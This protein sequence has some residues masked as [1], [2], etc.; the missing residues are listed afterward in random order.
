[1]MSIYISRSWDRDITASANKHIVGVNCK[2]LPQLGL[3]LQ[4]PTTFQENFKNLPVHTRTVANSTDWSADHVWPH[5]ITFMTRRAHC[6]WWRGLPGRRAGRAVNGRQRCCGAH[7]L[8]GQ[9]AE[10]LPPSTSVRC[11]RS[12]SS[13]RCSRRR[14]PRRRGFRRSHAQ[15]EWE[16]E[17]EHVVL[18]GKLAFPNLL[19]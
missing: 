15:L 17:L 11:P 14:L 7:L 12:S 9:N 3:G 6:Q 10:S 1:M 8:T 19:F 18:R 13:S 2:N 5:L 4:K 16:R